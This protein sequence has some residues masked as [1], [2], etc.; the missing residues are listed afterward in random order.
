[1]NKKNDPIKDLMFRSLSKAKLL[2][3]EEELE[4]ARACCSTKISVWRSLL[5]EPDRTRDVLVYAKR[6][7]PSK[8]LEGLDDSMFDTL[9]QRAS[10][11]QHQRSKYRID[12]WN[13]TRGEVATKISSKDICLQIGASL[14]RDMKSGR[15]DSGARWVSDVDQ[16]WELFVRLRN[17]FTEKN[18]RL[19]ISI[20]KRYRGFEIPHED[21]IQEGVFGLQRA[22]DLF[23]PERGFK[24]STYASWWIRASVQRHCR[25]KGRVVRIPV[26][27]QEAFEKYNAFRLKHDDMDDA[28]IARAMC[29]S[30]KKVKALRSMP[31]TDCF[32]LDGK[33]TPG[34][35]MTLGETLPSDS[36]EFRLANISLDMEMVSDILSELPDRERYI[37]ECRFGLNGK[38]EQTLQEIATEYDM[39][40]E[41]IRQIQVKAMDSIRK[42]IERRQESIQAGL[43]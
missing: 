41:R 7:M 28:D 18:M 42:R 34:S 5:G 43:R 27:M 4:L 23:D 32:S 29:I 6:R 39:S 1:M 2:T 12:R 31:K 38:E 13:Q 22:I 26:H 9:I 35:K 30:D 40:R 37:I 24:F 17:E 8:S 25:D 33:L 20:S 14:L 21:L 11:V 3:P 36:G 16:W 10:S 19:V 15:F